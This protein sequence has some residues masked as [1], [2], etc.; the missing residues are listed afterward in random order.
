VKKVVNTGKR[1]RQGPSDF[2]IGLLIANTKEGLGEIHLALC[3]TLGGT[4]AT[5]DIFHE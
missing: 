3:S 2:V 5:S 1:P 4:V